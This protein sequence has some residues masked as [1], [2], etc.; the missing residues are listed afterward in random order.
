VA[1]TFEQ[2]LLARN[3]Y[4]NFA[5]EY[6]NR[7]QVKADWRADPAKMIED[8]KRWV[9]QQKI[10]TAEEID[11]GLADKDVRDFS[12]L[13]IRAEI[14]NTIGGQEA[15]HRTL[16][17]ADRQLQ[18]ALKLFPKAGELLAQRRT[19]AFPKVEVKDAPKGKG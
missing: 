6:A 14:M 5:V 11:K 8:F 19:Q 9:V 17:A 15:R 4:V 7:N 1:Q 13:E 2:F 12:L 16:A 18:E 3:A 10:S